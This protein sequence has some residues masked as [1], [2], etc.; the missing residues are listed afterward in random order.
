MTLISNDFITY[1]PYSSP[2]PVHL[3]DKLTID[4]I[5]EGTI[6]LYTVIDNMKHEVQ[7]HHTLLVPSLTNSLFSIKTINC[8][9]YSV[10]FR[11]YSV[12]IENPNETVITESEEGGSLYNLHI[13]CKSVHMAS[14]THTTQVS[15]DILHKHLGHPSSS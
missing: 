4:A 9:G 13:V 10:L 1:H 5:G 12:L 3:A 8:L 2:Q 11:P 14:I 6:R 7:L 15:L